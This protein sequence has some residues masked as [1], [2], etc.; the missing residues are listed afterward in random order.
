MLNKLKHYVPEYILLSLYCTLILPYINYG[1]L[2][3]D[4]TYKIHIDKILKLQRW[5]SRTISRKHYTRR[6]HPDQLFIKHKILRVSDTF[7]P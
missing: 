7:K 3:W 4:N 1:I 5:A 6:C 2:L